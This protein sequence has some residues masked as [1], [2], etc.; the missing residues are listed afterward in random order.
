MTRLINKLLFMAMLLPSAPAAAEAGV[1]PRH[2]II[3]R[4]GLDAVW[5]SYVFAVVNDGNAPAPLKVEIALPKETAD[6]APQEGV[7]PEAVKLAAGA[8][9]GVLLIEKEFPPGTHVITIGFKVPASFGS[10]ELTLKPPTTVAD[11]TVL[12]PRAGKFSVEAS[13]LKPVDGGASPDPDYD[14][15]TAA[16]P[17]TAGAEKVMR[18]SGIPEG[19]ARFWMLGGVVAGLLVLGALAL[20]FKTRPRLSGEGA[21][22]VLVG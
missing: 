8:G 17:M 18:V 9:S 7:E 11:L 20:A 21:D 14:A 6:W 1:S 3:L 15:L 13:W 12:R 16:E 10:A 2:L 5:G 22:A 19:R 4:D